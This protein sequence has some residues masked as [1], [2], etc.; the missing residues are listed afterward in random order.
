MLIRNQV[1]TIVLV[2]MGPMPVRALG[3]VAYFKVL[4]HEIAEFAA[5]HARVD[6]GRALDVASVQESEA[7]FTMVELIMD[8][9]KPIY[10]VLFVGPKGPSE[11]EVDAVTGKVIPLPAES[12]SD[13]QRAEGKR[14][15][16]ALARAKVDLRQAMSVASTKVKGATVIRAEAVT[17]AS[18]A[19]FK[20]EL[21]ADHVFK[22]VTIGADGTVGTVAPSEVEPSGRAWTFDREPTYRPPTGWLFR[23]TNPKEGKARWTVEHDAKPMTGP[24]SLQLMAASRS[25]AFNLALAEG[26]S[27][28]DVDVRTRLRPDTGRIDQGGGVVWRA[29]DGD[30]YYV[31]RFNPLERNF[32][33]YKII[34]GKRHELQSAG[35][36]TKPGTWYAVRAK[37]IGDHI[38]CFLNGQKLLDVHDNAL[39]APG[40]IGLWTK[41]D[42]SS[43][44]DNVAVR[45]GTAEAS[46][47]IP[48]TPTST[49]GSADHD[50][51]DDED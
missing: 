2:A 28:G 9:P 16:A 38:M 51:D 20:V 4:G 44:F 24:N 10:E 42:A 31:C 21:L 49:A 13:E 25:R 48:R 41:A 32:R 40:M 27:Y 23:Y 26:T 18:S 37:M 5:E 39:R 50:D 19:T 8:G 29:K 34:D 22:M 14:L 33:V 36:A 43:T 45:N 46:D 47:A 1:A 3:E 6:A 12:P 17:D 11:V 7:V 15:R 35:I 30:N